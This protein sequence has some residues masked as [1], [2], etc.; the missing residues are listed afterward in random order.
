MPLS[1]HFVHSLFVMNQFGLI[2][3]LKLII[4]FRPLFLLYYYS[5]LQ[6]TTIREEREREREKKKLMQI[7]LI[8]KRNE[9]KG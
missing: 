6:T 4:I 3:I 7:E 1:F 8:E 5:K 9:R 2:E